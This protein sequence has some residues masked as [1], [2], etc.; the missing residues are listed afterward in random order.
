[1]VGIAAARAALHL[2]DEEVAELGALLDELESAT[3]PEDQERLNYAFH[4]AINVAGRSRRLTSVLALLGKALPS[5]FYEQHAEWSDRANDDHRAI[6]DAIDARQ[7]DDAAAAMS[8]HLRG[9]AEYAVK[10]L[11]AIG[12][13]DDTPD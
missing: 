4:R 3:D 10:A 6:L 2:S 7:P 8:Q 12:F 5:G 11:D 13:W 9:S 1:M